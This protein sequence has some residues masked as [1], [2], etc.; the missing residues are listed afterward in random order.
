MPN[1]IILKRTFWSKLIIAHTTFSNQN[2]MVMVEF[3]SLLFSSRKKKEVLTNSK[4]RC[5]TYI[6]FWNTGLQD[7]ELSELV[8][9]GL[10]WSR[11]IISFKSSWT[12]VYYLIPREF[13][14]TIFYPFF[15]DLDQTITRFCLDGILASLWKS[16]L[17]I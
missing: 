8:S 10:T 1:S 15:L 3:N 12:G 13:I 6:F 11:V 2:W 16:T 14:M 7:L 5:R 4:I 17:F 9:H